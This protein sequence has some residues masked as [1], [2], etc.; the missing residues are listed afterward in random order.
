MPSPVCQL[1]SATTAGVTVALPDTQ[2]ANPVDEDMNLGSLREV[3]VG[4]VPPKPMNAAPIEHQT[5]LSGSVLPTVKIEH[6]SHV[7]TAYGNAVTTEDPET[8]PVQ[9]CTAIQDSRAAGVPCLPG[10]AALNAEESALTPGEADAVAFTSRRDVSLLSVKD[11]EIPASTAEPFPSE[12]AQVAPLSSPSQPSCRFS[13][14]L[15]W[16]DEC[17]C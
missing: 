9:R 4:D 14:R 8:A 16:R 7:G 17:E 10:T 1:E 11:E 2:P 12:A 15:Y 13:H 6:G 3:Q 5:V